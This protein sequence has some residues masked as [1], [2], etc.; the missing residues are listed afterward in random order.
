MLAPCL[1][2]VDDVAGLLEAS[3]IGVLSSYNEGLPN[4]ILEYMLHGLPVVATDMAG[5]REVLSEGGGEQVV[6]AE[7]SDAFA[8]AL[9]ECGSDP[10]LRERI[11]SRNQRRAESEFSV[12]ATCRAWERCLV[13]LVSR[14]QNQQPGSAP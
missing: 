14:R 7:N 10:D 12:E 3:D 4:A 8:E 6:E 9:L 5:V 13:G 11:G 2:H 1:D